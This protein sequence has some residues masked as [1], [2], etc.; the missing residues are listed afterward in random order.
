[1]KTEVSQA[2]QFDYHRDKVDDTKKKAIH[3]SRNYD[4]FKARVAGCH[5][6]PIHRKEFNAPPKFASNRQSESAAS[7]AGIS[8]SAGV[9][10]EALS[11]LRAE[12]GAPKSGR[13]FERELRRCS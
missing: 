9:S 8:S 5:L 3:D 11:G 2:M 12:R 10:Q 6:K 7:T 4:D 13:E 1:M